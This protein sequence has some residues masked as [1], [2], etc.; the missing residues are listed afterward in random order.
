[1]SSPTD[2]APQFLL[3]L[4]PLIQAVSLVASGLGIW[5]VKETC[6]PNIY[7]LAN[8][9]S[10]KRVAKDALGDHLFNSWIARMRKSEL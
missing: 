10:Q 8:T 6:S 1:M 2:A 5:A 9:T 3:K 7:N 4:A